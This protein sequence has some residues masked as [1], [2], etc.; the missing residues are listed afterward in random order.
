MDSG[1]F[2]LRNIAPEARSSTR[3][4]SIEMSHGEH[5]LGCMLRRTHQ[6]CQKSGCMF[7]EAHSSVFLSE[8]SAHTN[9]SQ[10]D[11]YLPSSTACNR[12]WSGGNCAACS[13]E[14]SAIPIYYVGGRNFDKYVG[15][16][17]S[18]VHLEMKW[19][20]SE[21]NWRIKWVS[22]KKARNG[23]Q[24]GTSVFA[25][26]RR[27]RFSILLTVLPPTSCSNFRPEHK[28]MY[29]QR[30]MRVLRRARWKKFFCS[31][32]WYDGQVISEYHT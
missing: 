18:G 12:L 32:A 8:H 16:V 15:G 28:M 2:S 20:D 19:A 24:R 29:I 10:D 6:S 17:E 11:P 7:D 3:W 26:R 14:F 22:V 21:S 27:S 4:W 23:Q 13:T 9:Q 5:T 31:V 1:G 25:M 30:S